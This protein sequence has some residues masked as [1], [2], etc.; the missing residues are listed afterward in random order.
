L[1]L[2]LQRLSQ[3]KQHAG[4]TQADAA[5]QHGKAAALL[6]GIEESR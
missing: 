4:F 6:D 1:Q 2:L 3:S 5:N